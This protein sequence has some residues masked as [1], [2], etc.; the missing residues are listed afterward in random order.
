MIAEPIFCAHREIFP[1]WRLPLR[2]VLRHS[3]FASVNNESGSTQKSD[4]GQ[5][6]FPRKLDRKTRRCRYRSY[7][8]NPSYDCL[9]NNFE[10]SAPGNKQYAI[11]QRNTVVE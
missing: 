2:S 10:P 1:L 11:A 3:I 6:K 7:Y 9:L 8:W 5:T 4:Q